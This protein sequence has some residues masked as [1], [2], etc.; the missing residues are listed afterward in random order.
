MASETRSWDHTNTGSE[1]EVVAL[2]AEQSEWSAS[3]TA[4]VLAVVHE[5]V[6][7]LAADPP[8]EP[9][10]DLGSTSSPSPPGG[11]LVAATEASF[12]PPHATRSKVLLRSSI[13]SC[14]GGIE[15]EEST[16]EEQGT[17]LAVFFR[18]A[19][20]VWPAE[21]WDTPTTFPAS[22]KNRRNVNS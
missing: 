3:L 10:A 14:P 15:A 12:T 18:E 1:E 7:A 8:L 5:V 4:A 16:V 22:S 6:V 2:P 11:S 20:W 17:E 19:M 13:R 21:G 9:S